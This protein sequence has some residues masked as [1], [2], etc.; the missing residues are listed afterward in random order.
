MEFLIVTRS[1]LGIGDRVYLRASCQYVT[2][3]S[4]I[5]RVHSGT[6]YKCKSDGS[7]TEFTLPKQETYEVA[8]D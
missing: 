4:M 2:I 3:S 1:D 8:K 5:V 7:S 6:V